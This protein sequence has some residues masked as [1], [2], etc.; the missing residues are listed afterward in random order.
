MR[1]YTV[2]RTLQR[3]LQVRAPGSPYYSYLRLL[4]F[5]LAPL[6]RHLTFCS[7]LLPIAPLRI[8]RHLPERLT[9][10]GAL[11]FAAAADHAAIGL[12]RFCA[13]ITHPYLFCTILWLNYACAATLGLHAPGFAWTPFYRFARAH[14]LRAYT[15]YTAAFCGFF[16]CGLR[17]FRSRCP[18]A[19]AVHTL[20]FR[21][22]SVTSYG[23]PFC[24]IGFQVLPRATAC[25]YGFHVSRT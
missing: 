8:G 16:T 25:V 9:S 13:H 23:L 14:Y 2:P 17:Y 4:S 18:R 6:S 11:R 7:P 19:V 24:L 10:T 1:L 20:P 12:R 5:P 15:V 22:L 3:F 21:L